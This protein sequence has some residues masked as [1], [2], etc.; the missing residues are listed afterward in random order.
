MLRFIDEKEKFDPST[1]R[2]AIITGLNECES[3][4][5]QVERYLDGAGGKLDYRRYAETLFDILFA[6][7][8]LGIFLSYIWNKHDTGHFA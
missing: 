7:G 8:V 4:F 6:G 5:E 3:D 1:F 2:D